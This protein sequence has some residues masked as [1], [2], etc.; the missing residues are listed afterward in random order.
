MQVI[1]DP[2][3]GGNDT[4][5]SINAQDEKNLLLD[6]SKYMSTE[7]EK[8]GIKT[9]LTRTTDI[10]LTD[11]ERNSIINELKNNNDIII[12]NKL[13]E[14]NEFNIIY[15]LRNSDALASLISNNLTKN[16]INVDK[17]FQRRLPTDTKLDY[18]YVIRNT[19]PNET[20]IIEYPKLTEYQ[21]IVDIIVDSLSSYIN[22]TNGYIVKKG[23]TLW[24]IANK[25]NITVDN[26]KN[27][28]NLKNNNLS[29]GQIL[30][31]PEVTIKDNKQ[32]EFNYVVKKGDTLWSI[33]N[34]YNI[35]VDNLKKINNLKTDTLS[36]GQILQVTKNIPNQEYL[37]YFVKKGDTLWSIANKYKTTTNNI[38]KL[39]NL[40]TD[41]LSIG[42]ELKIPLS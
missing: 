35:T 38:I 17:Y 16:N 2:Y 6:I 14:N 21:K 36:I 7:L 22:K 29:I 9:E 5:I 30:K 20:L 42:Q 40:K 32:E 26:L 10:S 1:I 18:Y 27:L 3:R 8:K 28:N 23:D 19:K 34:K 12:Q 41:N 39:N 33:A 37:L 31:I 4:G 24:S 15:P 13:N 11:D 25:Y